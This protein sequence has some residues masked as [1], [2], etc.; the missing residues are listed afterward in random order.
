MVKWG[1]SF[2]A[3]WYYTYWWSHKVS[4]ITET[5]IPQI[6]FSRIQLLLHSVYESLACIKE[7]DTTALRS[8][9]VCIL[10]G[11]R[12][13]LWRLIRWVDMRSCR[14]WSATC[15]REIAGHHWINCWMTSTFTS[16]ISV[17]THPKIPVHW[18][19]WSRTSI[20]NLFGPFDIKLPTETSPCF[21][22]TPAQMMKI[23]EE[24]YLHF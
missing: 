20:I 12:R 18:K 6:D 8:L 7:R 19:F 22:N 11:N 23:H 24:K 15:R 1:F 16:V 3:Q 9:P 14:S 13:R 5:N 2:N 17:C 21:N 4:F 10:F